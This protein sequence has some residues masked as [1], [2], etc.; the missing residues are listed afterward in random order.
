MVP[1]T[2][3]RS[4]LITVCL[5]LGLTVLGNSQSGERRV[6]LVIGNAAYQYTTPL[7]NPVHDAQD[8]DTG[9]LYLYGTIH[10]LLNGHI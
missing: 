9:I 10:N 4:I 2:A 1:E 6:A 8:R 3:C 5:L 7:Q